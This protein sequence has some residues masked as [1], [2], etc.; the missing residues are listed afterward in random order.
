MREYDHPYC[1]SLD[2][3]LIFHA[4]NERVRLYVQFD[5]EW[6]C[7]SFCLEVQDDPYKSKT[8]ALILLKRDHIEARVLCY[9]DVFIIKGHELNAIWFQVKALI[10]AHMQEDF[11]NISP[12]LSAHVRK[13]YDLCLF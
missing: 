11:L 7:D 9:K 3:K 5:I 6:F 2:R 8:L 13:R 1:Y 4:D 12:D 10:S